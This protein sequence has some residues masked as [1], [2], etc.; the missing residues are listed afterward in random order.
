MLREATTLLLIENCDDIYT[1]ST[2]MEKMDEEIK[3]SCKRES[4]AGDSCQH[5][6]KQEPFPENGKWEVSD[7]SI[8]HCLEQ[9]PL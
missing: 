8:S 5:T 3:L 6:A 4:D 1:R 2:L 7:F 9:A